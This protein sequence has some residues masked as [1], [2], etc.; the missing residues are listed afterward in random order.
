MKTTVIIQARLGSTRLPRKVLMNLGGQSVI[1]RVIERMQRCQYVDQ[2]VVAT[3][4]HVIDDAIVDEAARYE[5]TA[6]RGSEDDVLDRYY[7]AA[8]HVEA[9][10]V[11]RIT[12]DCP[13]IDPVLIDRLI[14]EF[15]KRRNA[16]NPLDYFSNVHPRTFP[17]GLDAEMFTVDALRVAHRE[18]AATFERE[19]VTPFFY[20]NPKRFRMDNFAQAIDQSKLRWTLDE[21]ADLDFFRAV[22]R[23]IPSEQ[24]ITTEHVLSLLNEYPEIARLN[25]HIEQ[26]KLRA[27]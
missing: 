17:R 15:H 16:G 10:E 22:F 5:T 7:Q 1:G 11:I 3:T 21:T 8:I 4:D 24:F 12:A 19:H 9:T 14:S 26:K 18:A 23:K 6:V 27:A 20:L 25:S 2:V 13:L